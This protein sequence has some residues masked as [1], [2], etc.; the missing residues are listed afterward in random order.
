MEI[1]IGWGGFQTRFL[2]QNDVTRSLVEFRWIERGGYDAAPTGISYVWSMDPMVIPAVIAELTE[3][4]AEYDLWLVR[5]LAR[6]Q[7]EGSPMSDEQ[8][9]MIEAARAAGQLS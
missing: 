8:L 9:A 5:E 3:L 6:Y 4:K 2:P 7:A 1:R